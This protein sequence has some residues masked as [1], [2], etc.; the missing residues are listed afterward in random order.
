MSAKLITTL[1]NEGVKDCKSIILTT[2]NHQVPL[3]EAPNFCYPIEYNSEGAH[4]KRSEV[5]YASTEEENSLIGKSMREALSSESLYVLS[6]LCLRTEDGE[7]SFVISLSCPQG[8]L[9]SL[10]LAPPEINSEGEYVFGE[11]IY[12]HNPQQALH[13]LLNEEVSH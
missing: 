8:K 5:I 1:L 10:F 13:F 3:N 12:I 4:L 9:Y 2:I 6:V 11:P 7:L